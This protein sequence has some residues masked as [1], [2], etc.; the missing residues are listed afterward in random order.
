[1]TNNG[2]TGGTYLEDRIDHQIFLIHCA[3]EKTGNQLR[4]I[5][6]WQANR[7][8]KAVVDNML[9]NPRH[10][11]I[12]GDFCS[13]KVDPDSK[14]VDL[15]EQTLQKY[16]ADLTIL[17]AVVTKLPL[18]DQAR[19]RA[20]A[21]FWQCRKQPSTVRDQA[22]VLQ[23]RAKA[24]AARQLYFDFKR[25]TTGTVNKI[26]PSY[27]FIRCLFL[28]LDTYKYWHYSGRVEKMRKTAGG[29]ITY[30]GQPI[31]E[32]LRESPN[33]EGEISPLHSPD[34]RFKERLRKER[35]RMATDRIPSSSSGSDSFR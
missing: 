21:A 19:K 20:D 15:V 8:S 29:I 23:C 16:L 1:M 14:I 6:K 5:L 12:H 4:R 34:A 10:A 24:K 18:L 22:Q 26:L 31:F 13:F 27:N 17:R 9:A 33:N 7:A 2:E 25:R 35:A 30:I 32:P 3:Y 11:K 28:R